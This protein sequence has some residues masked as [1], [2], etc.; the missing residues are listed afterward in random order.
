VL[1]LWALL[2][3]I[4]AVAAYLLQSPKP[5]PP[6]AATPAAPQTVPDAAASP[7]GELRVVT[8]WGPRSTRVLTP[9]NVQPNGHSALWVVG[10]GSPTVK[11]ELGG[12]LLPTVVAQN[13]VTASVSPELLRT[14]AARPGN[15][16]VY[17]VG[18]ESRRQQ[19]GVFQ[20]LE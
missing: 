13:G 14:V 8:A 4:I 20:I 9:F 17:L 18:P 16:P 7:Q 10:T 6:P 3:A 11:L 19:V 12:T 2:L 5:T 1:W 15:L